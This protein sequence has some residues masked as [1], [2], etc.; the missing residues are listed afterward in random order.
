MSLEQLAYLAEIIAAIAVVPSLVYLV[1]QVRQSNAQG[2]ATARYAFVQ[3][4]SDINLLVA[5]D[6]TTASVWRRGLESPDALDDDELMQFWM[7]M[8]Q[9]A[10]AWMVMYQLHQ[11]GMLPE[12]QWS[13]VRKDILGILSSSG[14]RAFWKMGAKAFDRDFVHYVNALLESEE[15]PYDM[16]AR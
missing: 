1:V 11:D 16:L 12:N 2:R 6:K 13:V 3:A 5:Q 4:M 10:N 7:L 9:Y 8:G 15:Q 14:G